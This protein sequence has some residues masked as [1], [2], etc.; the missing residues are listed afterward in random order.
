LANSR[1]ATIKRTTEDL[2]VPL[3][4]LAESPCG[5]WLSGARGARGA[6][7]GRCSMPVRAPETARSARAWNPWAFDAS[8]AERLGET[9]REPFELDGEQFLVTASVG[10]ALAD[11]SEDPGSLIAQADAGSAGTAR[12]ARSRAEARARNRPFSTRRCAS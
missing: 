6:R 5:D 4:W 7:G 8:G 1:K 9:V 11:G 2:R 12:R 10:I 3:R